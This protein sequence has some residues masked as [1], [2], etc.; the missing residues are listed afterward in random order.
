[1]RPFA[2]RLGRQFAGIGP[3]QRRHEDD[4]ARHEHVL[5][6]LAQRRDHLRHVELGCDD[7]RD[8][9]DDAVDDV[10]RQPECAVDD[11]GDAVEMVVQIPERT[12][13]AGHVY[14]VIGATEQAE[15]P[16]VRELQ[17]VR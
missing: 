16:G 13:L 15:V 14:E 12:A 3:R 7:E 1:M 9:S 10:I 5:D 11:A 2:Q 6:A 8:R 17:N 4:A